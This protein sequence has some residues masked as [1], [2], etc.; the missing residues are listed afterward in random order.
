MSARALT[1][2][3]PLALLAAMS[4]LACSQAPAGGD[5]RWIAEAE[6]Q[7]EIADERL[8]AKDLVGARISL[9]PI[10]SGAVPRDVPADARRGVLQD[11]YFRLAKI[12][13]DVGDPRV[14]LADAE[15]GLALGR[16]EDLF[17]A[18]LLVVRGAAHEALHDGE[19]AAADYHAALVI[20]DRLLAQALRGSPGDAPPAPG[21]A[22]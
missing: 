20:N 18:N 16:A 8:G 21:G 22:P 3:V 10:V 12:D 11:T 19:A 15:R 14:A 7:H 9:L 13:L 4:L 5:S 1:L 17:V 6:R 2:V